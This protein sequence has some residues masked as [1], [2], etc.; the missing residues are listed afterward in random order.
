MNYM[1]LSALQ[2]YAKTTGPYSDKARQIY[3][4]LRTNLITNMFRIYEKLD[5]FGN[6]MMIKR[7]M[8]KVVIHLPD[9]H[10]LL[11]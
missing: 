10:H 4:Q 2:H 6:N 11:F 8:D 9:G 7:V 3:G 1:V 5:M